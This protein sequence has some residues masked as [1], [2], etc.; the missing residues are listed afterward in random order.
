[1]GSTRLASGG[2][3]PAGEES[4]GDRVAGG[5]AVQE[6]PRAPSPQL[7]AATGLVGAGLASSAFVSS[8][9][10]NFGFSRV[11]LPPI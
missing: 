10:S 2:G 11:G 5:D 9:D 8:L 7:F 1:M 4:E 6:R 3:D